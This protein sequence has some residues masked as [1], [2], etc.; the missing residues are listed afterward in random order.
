MYADFKGTANIVCEDGLLMLLADT[1]YVPGLGVNLLLARQI[2]QSGLKGSFNKDY[3][4]FKLY[5]ERVIEVTIRNRLYIITHVADGYH[6][7]AFAA[8]PANNKDREE[9]VSIVKY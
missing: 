3:M 2:C 8:F 5:K 7:K 9:I 6:N 4:F 1:L